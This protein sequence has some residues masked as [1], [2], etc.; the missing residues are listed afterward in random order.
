MPRYGTC[1][2]EEIVFSALDVRAG[3]KTCRTVGWRA[4]L[5]GRE[6]VQ[7][8]PRKDTAVMAIAEDQLHAVAHRHNRD[9]N[10]IGVDQSYRST[11][12]AGP[13]FGAEA[14]GAQQL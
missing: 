12:T 14:S 7:V 6:I 1:R 13:T 11:H 8:T 4:E 3:G 9:D 10:H 2:G 5:P